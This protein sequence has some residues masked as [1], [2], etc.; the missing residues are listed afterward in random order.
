MTSTA[1]QS[2]GSRANGID[3]L[4][5]ASLLIVPKP[6]TSAAVIVGYYAAVTT[7]RLGLDPDNH[8]VPLVT[9]SLDLL[10]A[11][12]LILAIAILGVT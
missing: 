5:R 3:G 2:D 12:S 7:F 4:T 1:R 8:S 10:G 11:L 6:A 9:S